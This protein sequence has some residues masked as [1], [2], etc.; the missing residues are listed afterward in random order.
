MTTRATTHEVVSRKEAKVRGAVRYF[1]GNPCKHG[2]VTVRYTSTGQ[3]AACVDDA[4]KRHGTKSEKAR[5]GA[6]RRNKR[7]MAKNTAR[8]SAQRRQWRQNNPEVVRMYVLNRRALRERATPAWFGEFDEFVMREAA[9]MSEL[10]ESATG[11]KWH[12]DHMLPL[13]A[14]KCSGLHVG[15]NIQVIPAAMNTAKGNKLKM[16]EPGEWLR[17]V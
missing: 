8:L 7:W 11:M 10:R 4:K 2:H 12:I 5:E 14:R 17:A 9:D 16:T 3:C 1:T 6:A 15:V 13:K